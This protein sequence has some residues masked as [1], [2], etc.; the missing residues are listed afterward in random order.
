[1]SSVQHS[2]ETI[3]DAMDRRIAFW[4][5]EMRGEILAHVSVR[6]PNAGPS[7]WEQYVRSR[8]LETKHSY[9]RPPIFEDLPRLFELYEARTPGGFDPDEAKLVPDDSIPVP[10]I[11]P[12]VNFGEGIV[13]AFFGGEPVFSSTD[14]KTESVCRPVV[15]DWGQLDNLR[16]DERNPW[17]QPVLEC[18]RFFVRNGRGRYVLQPYCTI[19]ALNFRFRVFD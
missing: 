15:T 7:R 13:G 4:R 3:R 11:C 2:P 5:R 18:L 6:R 16:F 19:D 12:T 17:V 14:V 9:D 10:R 1:V 8:H